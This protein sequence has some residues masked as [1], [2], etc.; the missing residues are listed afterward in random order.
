MAGTEKIVDLLYDMQGKID[1]I[2]S[3]SQLGNTTLGGEAAVGLADV[4]TEAAVTNE[5]LPDVQVDVADG[6]EGVSDLQANLSA[7]GDDL[8]ARFEDA[9]ADLGNAAAEIADSQQEIAD[10]FGLQIEG[11][12]DK[13]DEIIV[14]AGGSLQLYSD[15]APTSDDK[16]PPG[17]TWWM[18]NAAKNVVGQWQQTGTDEVPDWT[19]RPIESD[20]IANLDV[21]KLT[22]GQASI[23]Q[24]VAMKIAASTANIQTVNVANLFVTDGATMNQATINYLFANVVAA[25]K[26]TA[27][28][29][30]VNSLNGVTITGAIIKSAANGKR[31]EIVG[32]RID[33]YGDTGLSAASIEGYA[34]TSSSSA[35]LLK[36]VNGGVTGSCS[37]T[38]PIAAS[39]YGT[40]STFSFNVSLSHGLVAPSVAAAKVYAWDPSGVRGALV[41]DGSDI[42]NVIVKADDLQDRDGNSV[43]KDTG[44]QDISITAGTPVATNPPQYRRVGRQ[45]FLRGLIAPTTTLQTIGNLPAGFRPDAQIEAACVR[46]PGSSASATFWDVRVAAGGGIA[47]MGPSGGSGNINLAGFAP[48]LAEK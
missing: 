1:R 26:I 7:V 48:Y 31:I 15:E 47:L 16:A 19:P 28:M 33:V 46:T 27:D 41:V 40:S 34:A 21:A 29:L 6:N 24:V 25:K 22:A 2:G 10:A 9:A 17:S 36:A 11:L 5:A 44:W 42:T 20:V 35:L 3:R 13:I 37:L 4:V 43:S 18:I 32:Q 14:G 12:S 23:L 30:D 45:V 8:V 39:I 38:G